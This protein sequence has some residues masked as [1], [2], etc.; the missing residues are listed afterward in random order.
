[1]EQTASTAARISD[2]MDMILLLSRHGANPIRPRVDSVLG[3]HGG[4][5]LFLA[6]CFPEISL[7][8]TWN[9]V[10]NQFLSPGGDVLLFDNLFSNIIHHQFQHLLL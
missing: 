4:D 8:V 6:A 10:P 3:D 7:T 1:V 2:A 5:V 9:Q